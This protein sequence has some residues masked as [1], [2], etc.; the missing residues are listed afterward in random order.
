MFIC[1][2][3][4]DTIFM[5]VAFIDKVLFSFLIVS[6]FMLRRQ[7][8][9]DLRPNINWIG[10]YCAV[11]YTVALR[12]NIVE[13]N[14]LPSHGFMSS[15]TMFCTLKVRRILPIVRCNHSSIALSWGFLE[16]IGFTVMLQS[17]IINSLNLAKNSFFLFTIT[18]L[19]SGQRVN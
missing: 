18:L 2:V 19:G 10:V 11:V 9:I 14:I 16:V 12:A 13:A 6:Q 3:Y 8:I 15:S 5:F 17:L 1:V 4:L 7:F